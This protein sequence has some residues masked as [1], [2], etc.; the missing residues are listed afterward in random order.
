MQRAV[1][2]G[3]CLPARPVPRGA[4]SRTP[5]LAAMPGA[6]AL[7][8]LGALPA[9]PRRAQRPAR[10]G[11]SAVVCAASAGM[12]V[13]P[14]PRS[15]PSWDGHRHRAAPTPPSPLSQNPY[16]Y[17]REM[18]GL[19]A[20]LAALPSAGVYALGAALVV[21]LGGGA[22]AAAQSLAPGEPPRRAACGAPTAPSLARDQPARPLR[23]PP[24]SLQSR[25][26]PP[27]AP[28]PPPRAPPPAPGR[29]SS[30]PRAAAPPLPWS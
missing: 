17:P 19:T 4:T 29:R 16:K 1:L 20:A 22:S 23:A 11:A 25:S 6:A 24:L 12:E 14:A 26:A 15:L 3:V 8:A 18:D 5:L 2:G 7:R 13:R 28:P 30:S 27:R 9:R 10:A 21:A